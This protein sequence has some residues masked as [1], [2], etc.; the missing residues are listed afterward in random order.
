MAEEFILEMCPFSRKLQSYTECLKAI[1][2]DQIYD[3]FQNS[4]PELSDPL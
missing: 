3:S 4:F 1:V 2:K